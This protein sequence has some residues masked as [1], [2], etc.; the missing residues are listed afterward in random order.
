[1]HRYVAS[2]PFLAIG[3][4]PG[5]AFCSCAPLCATALADPVPVVVA[6]AVCPSPRPCNHQPPLRMPISASRR[7]IVIGRAL[8][9]HLAW[10]AH[11]LSLF[12]LLVT[13]Y[14]MRAPWAATGVQRHCSSH[15]DLTLCVLLCWYW[16]TGVCLQ[17]WRLPCSVVSPAW[18]HGADEGPQAER[19]S[20]TV[21][22]GG[23][24]WYRAAKVVVHAGAWLF[25]VG[26]G[27]EWLCERGLTTLLVAAVSMVLRAGSHHARGS[28]ACVPWWSGRVS[29]HWRHCHQ[30]EGACFH[31]G[32]CWE[33]AVHADVTI[34]VRSVLLSCAF[35]GQSH[36]HPM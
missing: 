2:S 10:Q 18:C 14:A 26:R 11:A 12:S 20:R 23:P 29:L 21:A 5:K 19:A 1:M 7:T 4:I 6:V 17:R 3:D 35:L 13:R 34:M 31:A 28:H 8:V 36:R 22:C 15:C 24:G 30:G 27:V 33:V 25:V 16:C 32:C 9:C